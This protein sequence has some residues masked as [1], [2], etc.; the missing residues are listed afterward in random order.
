MQ[1]K[2]AIALRN[3][4]LDTA[5]LFSKQRGGNV[6]NETYAVENIEVLSE[7]T[8]QVTFIKEPT[9]KKAVAWFYYINSRRK[10]RWDY[11]F[12][13]YSHLVGLNRVSRTLHEVEQH[14]FSIST[15]E[16]PA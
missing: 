8:A 10:P 7:C 14:N 3:A 6:L 15:R 12:V 11:F 1:K 13:T 4:A 16:E 2:M 5:V 9:G